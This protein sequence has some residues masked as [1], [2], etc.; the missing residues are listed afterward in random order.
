MVISILTAA[1][2]R[3]SAHHRRSNALGSHCHSLIVTLMHNDLA[4]SSWHEQP[5]Q[6]PDLMFRVVLVVFL[7][8]LASAKS[9]LI[10]SIIV[11][12]GI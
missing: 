2:E 4:G 5:S 10:S 7:F 11:G 12:E 6:L 9:H 8:L 3:F 1:K